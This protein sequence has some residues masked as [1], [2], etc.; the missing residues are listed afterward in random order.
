MTRPDKITLA[1]LQA[2]LSY[3][4]ASGEFRAKLDRPRRPAG[5]VAGNLRPDGYRCIR[6]KW[7]KYWA[8]HLAWFYVHGAWPA[9]HIDHVNGDRADNRISNLR[10]CTV[11]QNNQNMAPRRDNSSGFVGVCWNARRG[12][13]QANIS[14]NGKTTNL[15]LF[16]D[17]FE[18]HRVYL[19][20]KA[21]LHPFSRRA[22]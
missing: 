1:E 13:Y 17:P 12:K 21:S 18:A 10:E 6:L 2:E 22:A 11:A 20:A 4:P 16:D 9:D 8:H 15:G 14:V 7:R 19:E 5:S 3:D